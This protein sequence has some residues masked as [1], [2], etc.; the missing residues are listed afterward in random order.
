MNLHSV[1]TFCVTHRVA[2]LMVGISS[3][4]PLVV[5]PLYLRTI[6]ELASSSVMNAAAVWL[7][8]SGSALAVAGFGVY[9][10]G[11]AVEAGQ[12]RK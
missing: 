11:T 6:V 1:K 7:A 10:I 3:T 5:G 4:G 9:W 8:W 2:G 12:A